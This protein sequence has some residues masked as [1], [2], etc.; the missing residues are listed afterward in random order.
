MALAIVPI[1]TGRRGTD[2]RSTDR[3]R[4]ALGEHDD[5]EDSADGSEADAHSDT[6]TVSAR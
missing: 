2:T 3:R 1:T 4:C 5:L 6:F